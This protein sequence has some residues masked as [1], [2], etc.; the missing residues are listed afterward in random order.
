MIKKI[1]RKIDWLKVFKGLITFCFFLTSAFLK[2][3]AIC[4]F[5]AWVSPEYHWPAS[6]D[7]KTTLA[8]SVG[9]LLTSSFTSSVSPEGSLQAI[10]K[11]ILKIHKYKIAFHDETFLR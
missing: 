11:D 5:N 10:M 3:S 9:V 1:R 2:E 6:D 8:H 7:L 4:S